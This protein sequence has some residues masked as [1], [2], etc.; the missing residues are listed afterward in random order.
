MQNQTIMENPKIIEAPEVVVRFSGDS[1][2][3]MQLAGTIFSTVAAILGNEISTFPDYPAEMRAPVGSLG[4]VSSYQV[5]VG[6]KVY[7]P[8]DECDVL[9]AMNPAALRQ[10]AKYLKK[11]GVLIYDQDTFVKAG[12]EKAKFTTEDPFQEMGIADKFQILPVPVT[13]S[14]KASLADSGMD[15]KSIGRCRN[16]FALGFVFWLFNRPIEKAIEFLTSK[17]GKKPEI[18]QANIKVITD[19]Y[20]YGANTHASV[21]TYRIETKQAEPGIYCDVKGNAATAYGLVA[22]A[23]KAGL[24]L[25]LGSYPIT[26]ATD[27]LHELS[28]LKFLGVTTVQ[29]EDEIAGIC[30]AIGASFGGALAATSTSGPGI[31]LKSEA[32]G[33]AVM[34]ELPLV[35]IDVMRGGPSTGLPT[36]TEQTDLLQCLYGRNGECPAVVIAASSPVDCFTSAYMASKVAL[37]HNT[38]VILLTDAFIGNGSSS[39]RI[40]DIDA[41]PEIKPAVAAEGMVDYKPFERD[42]E[43]FVRLKAVPG[44]EGL[45]HRLGGLEKTPAGAITTDPNM[46]QL[47]VDNRQKKIDYIANVIP[48]LEVK[49]DKD[50]DTLV[51]GWGGTYGHI[52][53]AVENCRAAGMK[54]A[55]AHFNFIC[56]LPKN[57]EAVLKSYKNVLCCELNNGQFAG[58]LRSKVEGISIKQFNEVKG[59]PFQISDIEAAIKA[60]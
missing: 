39:F 40:E 3:G 45:M 57:T 15:A 8:G 20:N 54:V 53:A 37:E 29:A 1:G 44:T 10:N 6:K 21:S 49:G 46:H 52:A 38:P 5:H 42:S 33:L 23:E 47:M 7:T 31:A 48:E 58:Y 12:L 35:V 60:L 28:K 2:D 34:A 55:Q 14:T 27:V 43:T 13:E 25:F 16:I 26:P 11:G 59:Q 56:P 36:K 32:I 41:M 4:G 30:T 18:L 17:F 50:A 22:A 9:I 24:K 19:G 51:I